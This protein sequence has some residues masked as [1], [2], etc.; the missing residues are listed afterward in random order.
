MSQS[1]IR[2]WWVA[3]IIA[4]NAAF[5]GYLVFYQ[6]PAGLVLGLPE[7]WVVLVALMTVVFFSNS[8]FA[9]YYL[10]KPDI[11]EVFGATPQEGGDI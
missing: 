10:Q 11:R 8:V 4:S 5:M 2:R 6:N 3:F 9:W 1:Q 7:T